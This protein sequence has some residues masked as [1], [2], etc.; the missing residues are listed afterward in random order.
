MPRIKPPAEHR[1]VMAYA[2]TIQAAQQLVTG[3]AQAEE[4]QR[5]VDKARERAVRAIVDTWPE[6]TAEQ[7]E[8]LRPILAGTLPADTDRADSTAA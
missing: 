5:I 2:Q 1:Q 7:R 6:L 4:A 3:V 8:T